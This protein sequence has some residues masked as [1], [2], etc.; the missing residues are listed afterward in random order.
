MH[1][2]CRIVRVG[3]LLNTQTQHT[4]RIAA[5][6]GL[7]PN[8]A[9]SDALKEAINRERQ[10]GIPKSQ[11]RIEKDKSL[12]NEQNPLGLAV[13]NLRDEPGGIKQWEAKFEGKDPQK[14]GAAKGFI[15]NYEGE[16]KLS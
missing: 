12:E 7:I 5:S 10:A 16:G 8:F 6:F 9:K 3:L 1:E 13:T 4:S 11:I 14:Y 2:E 15:P